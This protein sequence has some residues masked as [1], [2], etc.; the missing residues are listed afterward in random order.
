[1]RGTLV[2]TCVQFHRL[3]LPYRQSY[4]QQNICLVSVKHASRRIVI[5]KKSLCS[6]H[7]LSCFPSSVFSRHLSKK[8]MTLAQYVASEEVSSFIILY[9]VQ[10]NNKEFTFVEKDFK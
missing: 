10:P 6:Y 2:Q 9:Y 3:R 7:V 4:S 1:M 8:L 5:K